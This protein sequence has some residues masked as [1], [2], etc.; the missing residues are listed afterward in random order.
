M[1]IL[2]ILIISITANAKL[3]NDCKKVLIKYR[4]CMTNSVMHDYEI[5][6]IKSKQLKC[7]EQI[8]K[9]IEKYDCK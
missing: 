7:R 6:V 1:K 4:K 3:S 2:L 9:R 5:D 8:T